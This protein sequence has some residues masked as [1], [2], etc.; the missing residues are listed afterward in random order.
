MSRFNL[1]NDIP[2]YK[3]VTITDGNNSIVTGKIPL[4]LDDEFSIKVSSKYGELW[5]ASPNN[6]MNIL[7]D[8][9][10][11]PSGQ[12]ALQ[13]VQIWQSTDPIDLSITVN[14]EMDSDPYLDVIV[15]TIALMNIALPSKGS[16]AE[17]SQVGE[18]G[19]LKKAFSNL[20]LKTLIP[21]GPNLQSIWKAISNNENQDGVISKTL[22]KFGE[23]K[24][25]YKVK[26]GYAT[27]NNV[28]IKNVEP[29][30]SSEMS[31]SE[32]Q[33]SKEPKYYPTSVS[34]SLSMETMEIATTDM[35]DTIFK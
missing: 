4:I 14:I 24:G 30:F 15:P 8:S 12:F 33:T 9:F 2:S 27:F 17:D 21:P 1:I 11:L 16:N 22:A 35:I 13:G 26:I 6:F 32:S 34:L 25:V 28:I 29:S 3:L 5:Q 20:K 18:N 10:G 31:I 7:S 19:G 23:A